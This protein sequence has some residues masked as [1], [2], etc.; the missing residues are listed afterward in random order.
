MNAVPPK[1][2]LRGKVSISTHGRDGQISVALEGGT[3]AFYWEFGGGDCIAIIHVPP[4]EK[5]QQFPKLA[6]FPRQEWL[7]ALAAEIS[8]QKCVGAR[9]V[10]TARA[11]ELYR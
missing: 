10:I 4:A 5:W 9:Q 1:I 8:A 11:I 7:L 2:Q 6:P 3:Q